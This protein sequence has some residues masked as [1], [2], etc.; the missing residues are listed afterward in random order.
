MNTLLVETIGSVRIITLNRPEKRN[1]LN[2]ELIADLKVALNEADADD[3]VRAIVIRGAGKDFCS[4]ADLSALQKIASASHEENLEDARSLGESYKLIRKVRQPVIAAVKG[5]AL[6]GGFGLALA[7]DVIFAHDEA[8]FGF[9]EVKIGF[10]PAM[11]AAILR[12]NMT[13]KDAFATLTLGNEITA[14]ELRHRGIVEAII[15]GED[16]DSDVIAIAKQYE[17][18][19][20]SAV[21]MTKRLLYDI[22]G[23]DFASAIEQGAKV[24]AT[25]R[26]TDDCQKG[27]AKFL[28]K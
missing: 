14:A 2:D 5:R 16:F 10:V 1:A 22:D 27:I 6:A 21:Q 12:R 7:C 18:L 15:Q 9:P 20:A 11:V 4:G 19:S 26:M 28:E 25:A 17:K 3:N 13:E 8:R 24:N 23:L